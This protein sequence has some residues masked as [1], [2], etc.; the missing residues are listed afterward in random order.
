MK[1]T[2]SKIEEQLKDPSLKIKYLEK[3]AIKQRIMP[4]DKFAEFPTNLQFIEWKKGDNQEIIYYS[5]IETEIGK[6]LIAN[7]F[8][9]VCFLGFVNKG[10]SLALED[11]KRRFPRQQFKEQTSDLQ[12]SAADYCNGNHKQT[13]SLHMKG[14]DFQIDIWKK[15]VR[16]PEG[17]LSTYGFLIPN[18]K[19]ARAI[20]SAVGANPVSYIVPCHRIIR[21]DGSYQGYYWGLEIKRNLLAY[22]LQ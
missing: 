2:F 19:G 13:I 20:G 12:K 17:K 3:D 21:N 11:L 1:K 4:L 22:E 15:L 7:T 6:L 5:F 16:I 10:E 9:G 18:F 8:K 14:T